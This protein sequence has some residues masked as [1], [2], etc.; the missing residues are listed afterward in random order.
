MRK[1]GRIYYTYSMRITDSLLSELDTLSTTDLK[2]MLY[3]LHD[4]VIKLDLMRKPIPERVI[5]V[6]AKIR[7]EIGRRTS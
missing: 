6:A 3:D 2:A 1:E 5:T 7:A 4:E